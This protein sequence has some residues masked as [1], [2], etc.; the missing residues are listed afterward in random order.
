MISTVIAKPT[1]ACNADCTY[2]AAP[3]DGERAWSL[4]RFSHYFDKVQSRLSPSVLWLWHGGEPM[5]LKPS[6]YVEAWN[7][8]RARV[9]GVR[10][11][12][13]SNLLLYRSSTWRDV[14]VEVFAGRVSTSF[15]P[16][17]VNRT[18]GG[19]PYKYSSQFFGALE[20]VLS[21]GFR[22]MVIGTYSEASIPLSMDMYEFSRSYGAAAFPIRVNYRYPAGRWSGLTPS[23]SPGVYGEWLVRLYDRWV[24]EMPP[25][26]ITPLDQM[27][28]KVIGIEAG[29]CPWTRSCGGRIIEIEPNGDVY[30]CG[31]YADLQ[32]AEYRF[33][34]IGND[35]IDDVMVSAP[36]MLIRRRQAVLP[37]DCLQCRHFA[38]CEGGCSRDS[39]LFGNG[40]LGKFYYCASWK[41]VFDRLKES[42]RSGEADGL[43]RRYGADPASVRARL[44]A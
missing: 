25:F 4:R 14:F 39:A 6:F 18:I 2:C 43:I 30:Q 24:V 29:R 17:I 40:V 9:P 20:T 42:V 7:Y 35:S 38:E 36:A 5:L 16:D 33:G 22:P 10:F 37:S 27:L 44:A 19:D 21:D 3:P 32:S 41:R 34:N 15:D 31:E 12:M 11:G 23:I 28:K 8:A 1:R 13:Q 26:D